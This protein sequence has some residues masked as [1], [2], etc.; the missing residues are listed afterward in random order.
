MRVAR[1]DHINPRYNACHLLIDVKTI[2]AEYDNTFSTCCT[3]FLHHRV[4]VLVANTEG[5][6]REHPSGIGNGHIRERLTDHGDL[7]ATALKH[8]VRFK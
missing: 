4:H 6:L 2:V 1:Q 3:D 7:G 5:V 8:L